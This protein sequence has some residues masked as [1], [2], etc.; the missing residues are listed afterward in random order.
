MSQPSE[1]AAR[2]AELERQLSDLQARLP[3]HSVAPS[4]IAELDELEMAL[5]Q[6]RRRWGEEQAKSDSEHSRGG[7]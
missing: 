3:A 7:N 1:F 2:V 6:A 5:A 4:M